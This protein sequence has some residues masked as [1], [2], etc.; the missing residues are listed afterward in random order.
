MRA[1]RTFGSRLKRRKGRFQA[2]IRQRITAKRT[3][4]AAVDLRKTAGNSRRKMQEVPENRQT[5]TA[6]KAKAGSLKISRPARGMSMLK[7][8]R[9][10]KAETAIRTRMPAKGMEVPSAMKRFKKMKPARKA[11]LF[12]SRKTVW[13]KRL[14]KRSFRWK[15]RTG[16]AQAKTLRKQVT[17]FKVKMIIRKSRRA[18]PPKMHRKRG[19]VRRRRKIL[20]PEIPMEKIRQGAIWKK[21]LKIFSKILTGAKTKPAKGTAGKNL[22]L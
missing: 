9:A 19:L 4:R 2:S 1:Q 17:I 22:R 5:R 7:A 15:K 12:W 3:I 11:K 13:A 14:K 6:E 16:A 20:L 10:S 18:I 21:K 8:S